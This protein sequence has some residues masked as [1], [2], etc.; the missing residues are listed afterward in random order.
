MK[1]MNFFDYYQKM[2][3]EREKYILS[4]IN[5]SKADF[6]KILVLGGC[7]ENLLD[8]LREK[9]SI[10]K[11]YTV[12]I[13]DD[14]VNKLRQNP[15]NIVAKAD[16][17]K[18]FPFQGNFFDLV[19]GDQVIEHIVDADNFLAEIYRILRKDG[20]AIIST[21]NLASF[22]NIISLI[23]GYRPFSVHY[24][25]RKNVGNPLSPHN[26]EKGPG[27]FIIGGMHNKIFTPRS[28][29]EMFELYDF[30]IEK[31]FY[32]G[33][34]PLPNFLSKIFKKRSCFMTFLISK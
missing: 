32:N 11:I 30:N 22:A 14:Y 33:F 2:K 13:N 19:V 12:D 9:S 24:S 16:L 28:L 7:E 15:K 26:Y 21:E 29:K 27:K 10:E 31:E 4:S 25:Y 20:K 3:S 1:I 6:R 34:L 8:K 17:N 5:D 23:L 18:K